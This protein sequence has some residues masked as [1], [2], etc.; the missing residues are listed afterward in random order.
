M[1]SDS[2]PKMKLVKEGFT[3]GLYTLVL[4]RLAIPLE[5]TV[6]TPLSVLGKKTCIRRLLVCA[7]TASGY[8]SRLFVDALLR[9]DDLNIIR[10]DCMQSIPGRKYALGFLD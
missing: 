1:S 6:R 4:V 2:G 9:P 7:E 5:F 10:N 8:L 3:S